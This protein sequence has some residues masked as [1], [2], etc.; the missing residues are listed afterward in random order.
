[1]KVCIYVCMYVCM[2]V[3]ICVYIMYPYLSVN[4]LCIHSTGHLIGIRELLSDYKT[5]KI[6]LVIHYYNVTCKPINI[7]A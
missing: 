6:V 3:C 4:L 2:Y 1:M 7:Q 5:D